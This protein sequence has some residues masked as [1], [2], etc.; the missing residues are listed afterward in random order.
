LTPP[1]I[2]VNCCP[3]SACRGALIRLRRE[4]RIASDALFS[5]S[6]Q[7]RTGSERMLSRARTFN[8]AAD[9][10]PRK[11]L[12]RSARLPEGFS[13]NEAAKTCG[14]LDPNITS[15]Y[16]VRNGYAK[17]SERICC[18]AR[19]LGSFLA[20]TTE[21]QVMDQGN[22]PLIERLHRIRP[23]IEALANCSAQTMFDADD[24]LQEI[25][26]IGLEINL[27]WAAVRD[28][29]FIVTA[30]NILR[31]A[32]RRGR[33]WRK[34]WEFR[35]SR[36]DRPFSPPCNILEAEELGATVRRRLRQLPTSE[37]TEVERRFF[38]SRTAHSVKSTARTR[39]HRA[40]RRLCADRQLQRIC[41]EF[42][43]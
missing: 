7:V 16:A 19:C 32:G 40:K 18:L 6:F 14:K 21:T 38:S 17:A 10:R 36:S 4:D 20:N 27:D 43:T 11:V 42:E 3:L 8:V 29:W 33:C 39:F 26:V 13:F 1:L 15:P 28:G 24:L 30:R 34:Y 9:V 23:S 12:G 37:R 31:T 25:C 41:R 5:H 35:A 2:A 22:R